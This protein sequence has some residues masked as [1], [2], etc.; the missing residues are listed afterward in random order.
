MK[1]LAFGLVVLLG[2]ALSG[3]AWADNRDFSLINGTGYQIKHVYIDESS[4]DAWTDDV[5]GRDVLDNGDSVDISFGKGDKG[6]NWDMKVTYSD[7][8]TAT[9]TGFNLC[10][11]NSIKLLW[12]KQTG[13]TTAVTN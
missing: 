9:W 8:E 2:A 6:C 11:I 5:L 4:S 7:G 1:K 3:S 10:T 12:N 13:V